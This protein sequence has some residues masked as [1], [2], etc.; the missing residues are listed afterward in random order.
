MF[1]KAVVQSILL[2]GSETWNITSTML[3]TLRGFHHMA[4]RRITVRMPYKE[5]DR[6]IYPPIAEVSE[7]AGMYTIEEYIE[8]RRRHQTS[9]GFMHF[10]H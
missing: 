7:E 8:K 9:S 4:A 6:W 10:E 3:K 1:Y 2:Y 5:G